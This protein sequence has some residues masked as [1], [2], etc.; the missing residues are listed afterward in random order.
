MILLRA[1]GIN[2]PVIRIFCNFEFR[3]E[4]WLRFLDFYQ[5]ISGPVNLE[6]RLN[7]SGHADLALVL[8]CNSRPY[9]VSAPSNRIVKLCREPVIRSFWTHRF[10]YHHESFFS[11]VFMRGANPSHG[12]ER[13][14]FPVI[15]GMSFPAQKLNPI[16]LDA[17]RHKMSI[18]SSVVDELPGHR[19]RNELISLVLD[20][21]EFLQTHTYGRGRER[22]LASKIDGL[23]QYE[24]SLAVENSRQDSYIS[25]KFTDCLLA[26]A[27][28]V[29]F[30][31]PNIA[32]FFPEGSFVNLSSTD[33]EEI[34]KRINSL[35]SADYR[36][37]VPAMEAAQHLI[38]SK[39]NLI[40]LI[41]SVLS[42]EPKAN[43]R[44]WTLLY[45]LDSALSGLNKAT[46]LV[47]S[48]LP[49]K[50][51]MLVRRILARLVFGRLN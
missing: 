49:I 50:L 24:Y 36:A 30:G 18:I 8:D 26:G 41:K 38:A 12:R 5:A 2:A 20:K 4:D 46:S 44:T 31:A 19:I 28:P 43:N 34:V 22:E 11:H 35:T 40:S 42:E 45:G 32:S 3:I 13:E 51:K 39:Y 14:L 29:Y 6:I 21:Y 23:L 10:T 15:Y 33:S 7:E 37:R 1:A 9:W 48:K 16:L 47:V 27:V 17:K 25:E